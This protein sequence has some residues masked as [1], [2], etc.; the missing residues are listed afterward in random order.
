MPSRSMGL[1]A[2]AGRAWRRPWW[3]CS[4]SMLACSRAES[5]KQQWPSPDFAGRWP[6]KFIR[7]T[8]R[9]ETFGA[10][11][12]WRWC[13]GTVAFRLAGAC[14]PGHR[15]GGRRS[16]SVIV[17][18]R[19][20]HHAWRLPD[21]GFPIGVVDGDEIRGRV[22]PSGPTPLLQADSPIAPACNTRA[23][24]HETPLSVRC[25]IGIRSGESAPLGKRMPVAMCCRVPVDAPVLQRA[26]RS[27]RRA[28]EGV[29]A[30]GSAGGAGWPSMRTRA[31][32]PEA[33]PG[34]AVGA[35]RLPR[36]RL[37]SVAWKATRRSA[38]PGAP[39]CASSS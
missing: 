10:V 37:P 6:F 3:W 19:Q 35:Q 31:A 21:L 24:A 28:G 20:A 34:H 8:Q 11:A 26:G 9:Q 13:R 32:R 14:P 39:A 38:C 29:S 30:T 4:V 7:G 18:D 23:G 33:R 12:S 36:R 15:P 25:G 17:G 27:R 2:Q 16:G 5:H 1:G 22:A